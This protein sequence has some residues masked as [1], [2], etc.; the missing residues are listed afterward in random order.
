MI[1]A[2]R[3]RRTIRKSFPRVNANAPRALG[4]VLRTCLS[5]DIAFIFNAAPC[6]LS[7]LE[8][9]EEAEVVDED[10]PPPVPVA[11][12]LPHLESLEI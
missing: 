12:A 4:D 8:V 10:D 5:C 2:G 7:P 11:E 3:H 1:P 9:D 6:W